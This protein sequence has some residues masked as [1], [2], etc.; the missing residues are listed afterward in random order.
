MNRIFAT[1][2]SFALLTAATALAQSTAVLRMDIPFEFRVGNTVLPAGHYQVLPQPL[3]NV[4]RI[5]RLDCKGGVMIQTHAVEAT[6][7]PQTPT[8]EFH[9][10]GNT[11]FLSRVWTPGYS[12]GRELRETKVE[13]ELARAKSAAT[14]A[15][16]AGNR[17]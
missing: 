7:I 3:Q 5:T 8:M 2:S 12:Q 6:G 13:R 14:T 11:Y 1:L 4:L 10:Y 15:E 16:I 9:R 17:R